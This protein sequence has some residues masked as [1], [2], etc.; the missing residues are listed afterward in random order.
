M[1]YSQFNAYI[2]F[3][4]DITV[5]TMTVQQAFQKA[6]QMPRC[7]GF[8]HEGP[9]T[10]QPVEIFFKDH[11]DVGGEGWTSYKKQAPVEARVFGS[12]THPVQVVGVPA[13]GVTPGQSVVAGCPYRVDPRQVTASQFADFDKLSAKRQESKLKAVRAGSELMDQYECLPN[14]R[15]CRDIIWIPAILFVFLLATG[16]CGHYVVGWEGGEIWCASSFEHADNNCV[17]IADGAERAC[18][19]DDSDR[20]DDLDD[21]A[22]PTGSCRDDICYWPAGCTGNDYPTVAEIVTCGVAGGV[23]SLSMAMV[24]VWMMY[25]WPACVVYTSLLVG[26]GM[27]ILVGLVLI[28]IGAMF[29]GV[30]LLLLGLLMLFCVFFCYRH[31]IPFMIKLTEIVADI[32]A[33]NPSMVAISL[34]GSFA[35]IAWSLIVGFA[36]MGL[37]AEHG[38]SVRAQSS[39]VQYLLYFV[40]CLVL[41]W[42]SMA[43][44]NTCHVTYAGVFARWYFRKQYDD[45][46]VKASFKVATTSSFGSIC[47]GSFLIAFIRALEMVIRKMRLDQ[48]G[49]GNAVACIMLCIVE[50]IIGCIGDILE[51]FSE[52][53]YVQVAVRG[54]SFFHAA[55]ITLS[56]C[57][58]ANMNYIL[59]DLLLD[60]V[61]TLG[62]LMCAMSGALV[63]AMFGY[64]QGETSDAQLLKC[65]FGLLVGFVAGCIAGGSA[66]G[67]TSSGVKTILV[68]WAENPDVLAVSNPQIHE[69]FD[70]RM[71]IAFAC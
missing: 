21:D 63:G 35:G 44:Y 29:L 12:A 51:Y 9:P 25:K 57:T 15:P 33:R 42:G 16:V 70:H 56:L 28:S 6:S 60:Y 32:I 41:T 52:W 50:C 23:A 26:P 5:R 34:V 58:C 30:I 66:V 64:S 45:N 19:D 39:S 71:Q 3:G 18:W 69:E 40:L 47:C 43:A 2:S 37:Y 13:S 59:K 10:N 68:L 24:Y 20:P 22:D 4:G 55:K 38:D 27:T 62:T 53:A 49:S 7:V 17:G 48:E 1:S 67:I 61:V 11:W 14:S 65:I 36:A 31:L 46:P 8:C 54:C